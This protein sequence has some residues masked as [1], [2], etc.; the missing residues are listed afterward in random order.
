VASELN[1]LYELRGSIRKTIRMGDR[2]PI[3]IRPQTKQPWL[4]AAFNLRDIAIDGISII[5]RDKMPSH[6]A[7]ASCLELP[8]VAWNKIAPGERRVRLTMSMAV[9]GLPAGTFDIEQSV[10]FLEFPEDSVRLIAPSPDADAAFLDSIAFTGSEPGAGPELSFRPSPARLH[11][12]LSI[13][14]PPTDFAFAIAARSPDGTTWPLMNLRGRAGES[15]SAEYHLQ[16]A[17]WTTFGASQVDIVFRPDVAAAR[18][19][20]DLAEIYGGDVVI[21]GVRVVYE[22]EGAMTTTKPAR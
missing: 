5:D 18:E 11:F 9:D 13:D 14:N 21:K 15:S 19:S 12:W 22:D 6:G 1:A 3:D 10:S 4:S 8:P 16:P 7:G 20:H 17:G 2:I